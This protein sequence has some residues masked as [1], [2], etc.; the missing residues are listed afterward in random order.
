MRNH[1]AAVEV[2]APG[3][4]RD[5]VRA[6]AKPTGIKSRGEWSDKSDLGAH[7]YQKISATRNHPTREQIAEEGC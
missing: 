5:K 7:T 4:P 2:N 1:Q 6:N 3:R